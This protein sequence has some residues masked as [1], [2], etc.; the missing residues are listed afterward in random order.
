VVNPKKFKMFP[1]GGIQCEV[2]KRRVLVGNASLFERNQIVMNTAV[3][4]KQPISLNL[5]RR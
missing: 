5:E 1:G 2:R 4:F 3:L